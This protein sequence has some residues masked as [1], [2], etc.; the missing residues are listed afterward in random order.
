MIHQPKAK[1]FLAEQRGL[2][3]TNWF[4]SQHTFNF[5]KYFSEHKRPFGDLYVVND[6][7]LDAGRSISMCIE[8]YS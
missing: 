3:E 6:E 5:G 2:N 4:R 1:M 8:E 7:A